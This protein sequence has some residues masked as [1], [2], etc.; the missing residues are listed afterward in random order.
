MKIK[1]VFAILFL[2]SI[3][4]YAQTTDKKP[5]DF[6]DLNKP[7]RLEWL[8]D[9]GFGMF[10]HFSFDSQLGVVISHS[11]AG[12]SQDYLDRFI[13][14]LPQ[15][16]LTDVGENGLS[17]SGGQRQKIAF[18]RLLYR[19]PEIIIMDEATSALDTESEDE[20]MNVV[21]QLKSEGKTIIMIAHR[22]S[23]V[24][25][26]DEIVVMEKGKVIESGN[27]QKLYS[28]KGK[29][30]NLWQKQMPQLEE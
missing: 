3:L 11:M 1:F 15:G 8:K 18:A 13:N 25:N 20:I 10:I 5:E 17:L 27:H 22:L 6:L 19:E 4:S 2:G 16:L 9:A 14:E 21:H 26:A 29:Y 7:E 23:T 24:L 28:Q 12:A 30:Y